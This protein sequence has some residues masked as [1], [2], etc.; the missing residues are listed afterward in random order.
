MTWDNR[1]VGQG[2][3]APDQ[4]LA[5]P[6]NWRVHPR[7]QQIAL[8]S[9]LDQVGWVQR[10]IVNQRT[11]HVVDGH[12]RVALAISRH[13]PAVPVVYIDVSEDEE[14]LILASLD[15]LAHMA[16]TDQEMLGAL[17]AD[18]RN[19]TLDGLL[20]AVAAE[21][22]IDIEGL[23]AGLLPP[24][25][26]NPRL[27]P[28]DVIYTA[29]GID[30]TALQEPSLVL[31]HCC[32]A[33]KAGWRYGVQS[34][35]SGGVCLGA[36]CMRGH[37]VVF[38]DSDYFG[39][40]HRL[41]LA[42]ARKWQPKY[43]TVRDVMTRSQCGAAG[44]TYYPLE[45]VL[46]WAAEL[47]E[48]ARNV[49]VIPKYDCLDHIPDQYVLGYSEPT[50]HGGTPLPTEAFRGR[51]V[52]L[53]GGSWKSQLAH[54][55]VLGNDVV[56]LDNNYVHKIA[57]YGKCVMPDGTTIRLNDL[58]P[59]VDSSLYVSLAIS[60]ASIATMV[61]RLYAGAMVSEPVPTPGE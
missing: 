11:G 12:L 17:L 22:N 9:V 1:I 19:E 30:R 61:N 37:E 46:D 25:M 18:L 21:H 8:A 39:Y 6:R 36:T 59:A 44:I 32:V 48:Y 55:A 35:G 50:S 24:K 42:A 7:R 26:P 40:D 33:I 41:H 27:L 34:S 29:G 60:Y 23:S 57:K 51:R 52:H 15:P 56:S 5:N 58:V 10:V 49:I 2:T 53:L 45:Q 13:E 47:S 3:E 43:A 4:L 20:G 28:I 38:L 16:V 54:L 31:T 14:M